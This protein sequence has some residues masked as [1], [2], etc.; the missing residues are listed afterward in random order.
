MGALTIP[1]HPPFYVESAAP[2][3]RWQR[4]GDDWTET[5]ERKL[6]DTGLPLVRLR[7]L[8]LG[9]RL[10]VDVPGPADG[11]VPT[12]EAGTQVVLTNLKVNIDTGKF[13]AD[14]VSQ[15]KPAGTK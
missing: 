4:T 5:E 14:N 9:G 1:T 3:R 10:T 13:T 2:L 11:S 6:T 15:Q 8:M 12:F 7:I